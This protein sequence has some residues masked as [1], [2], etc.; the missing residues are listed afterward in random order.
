[1]RSADHVVIA[2]M[3]MFGGSFIRRIADAYCAAD[4]VNRQRLR[5][6]FADEWQKYDDMARQRRRELAPGDEE[7]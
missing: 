7:R 3:R 2:A 4:D 5:E 1:M 6:T